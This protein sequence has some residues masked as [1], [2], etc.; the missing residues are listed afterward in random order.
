M[1][2][3]DFINIRPR[4]KGLPTWPN[5]IQA[6]AI[7]EFIGL[8]HNM[9]GRRVGEFVDIERAVKPAMAPEILDFCERYAEHP[10]AMVASWTTWD[11]SS[12]I[13]LEKFFSGNTPYKH[14]NGAFAPAGQDFYR[15]CGDKWSIM[16]QINM[17]ESAYN[18]SDPCRRFLGVFLS[19][20]V[21]DVVVTGSYEAMESDLVIYTLMGHTKP[22]G[23]T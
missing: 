12:F 8:A 18:W 1:A 3:T 20:I 11:D 22:V 9:I 2:H 15:M 4:G 17:R 10:G 16:F 19:H 13:V 7:R 6:T 14:S 5:K 21:V 23:D